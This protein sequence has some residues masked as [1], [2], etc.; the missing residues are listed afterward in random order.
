[1]AAVVLSRRRLLV[2]GVAVAVGRWLPV[3][4]AARWLGPSW[5]LGYALAWDGARGLFMRVPP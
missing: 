2:G 1:M 4:P 3:G 5:R